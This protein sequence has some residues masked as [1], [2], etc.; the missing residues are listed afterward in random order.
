MEPAVPS[1][2]LLSPFAR[3]PPGARFLRGSHLE[4]RL[5]Y[6]DWPRGA[7]QPSVVA[8]DS[9]AGRAGYLGLGDRQVQ[10]RGHGRGMQGRTR[11]WRGTCSAARTEAAGS[12]SKTTVPCPEAAKVNELFGCD[13]D[14]GW[15]SICG[16]TTG[17]CLS[18]LQLGADVVCSRATSGAPTSASSAAHKAVASAVAVAVGAMGMGAFRAPARAARSR[19]IRMPGTRQLWQQIIW[20]RWPRPHAGLCLARRVSARRARC[21]LARCSAPGKSPR[22]RRESSTTKRAS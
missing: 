22:V 5:S 10:L 20:P 11:R 12:P 19:A 16:P 7:R 3:L 17:A 15:Y 4:R 13:G 8:A 21:S 9:G 1:S 2:G 18:Q 6:F 14:S